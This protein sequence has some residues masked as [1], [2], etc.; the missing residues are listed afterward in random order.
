M[1]TT[2]WNLNGL[3]TIL[4]KIDLPGVTQAMLYFGMWRAMFAFHT[5]HWYEIGALKV[6]ILSEIHGLL[7][8]EDMDLYSINYLHTGKPKFWYGVPP[9]AGKDSK[10]YIIVVDLNLV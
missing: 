3:N 9:D 1:D 6:S 5:V 8:Q 7:V 2:S 10:S 4:R